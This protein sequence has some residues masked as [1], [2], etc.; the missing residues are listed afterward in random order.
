MDE[1][2][3]FARGHQAAET[4]IATL[5][6]VHPAVFGRF[7]RVV[8]GTALGGQPVPLS[9]VAAMRGLSSHPGAASSASAE[10]VSALD[11]MIRT[12]LARVAPAGAVITGSATLH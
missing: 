10:N 2:L 8:A 11:E 6:G 12:V 7:L 9:A 4:L 5:I 1:D 3:A